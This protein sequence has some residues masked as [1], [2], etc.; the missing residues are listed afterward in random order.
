MS[1]TNSSVIKNCCIIVNKHGLHTRSA[2][3]IVQLAQQFSCEISLSTDKGESDANDMLRLMLLEASKGTEI[4]VSAKGHQADKA[5]K[6]MV[7]FIEAGF[8]EFDD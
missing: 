1:D 4:C 3:A 8:D 6:A 7:S 5:V 2:S